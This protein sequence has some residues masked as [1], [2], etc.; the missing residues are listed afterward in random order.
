MCLLGA[1]YAHTSKMILARKPCSFFSI[2]RS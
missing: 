2:F 1:L